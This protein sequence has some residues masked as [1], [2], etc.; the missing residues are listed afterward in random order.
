MLFL[1]DLHWSDWTLFS[2]WTIIFIV[3]IVVEIQTFNL[4][5]IWFAIGAFVALI[6]GITFAKPYLQFIIFFV[7]TIAAIA[8]TRPFA[9]KMT[10][11]TII[12]TNVDRHIGKIGVITKEIRPFEIGEVKVEN[13]YWKAIN[14]DNETFLVG[15]FI[16]VDGIEGIKFIVSKVSND[17]KIN[18]I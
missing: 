14:K 12:R 18:I 6:C 11:R 9:K 10:S 5:S 1:A 8:A 2:L 13:S 16:I 4:V 3:A 7:V 17:E 15:E